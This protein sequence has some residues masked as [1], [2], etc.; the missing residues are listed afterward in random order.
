MMDRDELMHLALYAAKQDR[1][2]DAIGYLRRIL[3]EQPDD[4]QA[5]YMLGALHA[6]IGMYD[7][8]VAEMSRAVEVAPRALPTASFQLGLLHLTAGRVAEAEQAWASLDELGEGNPLYLFKRGMLSLAADRFED[9]IADLQQGIALN[10]AN[11][12]LNEDMRKVIARAQR[13]M[14]TA[15]PTPEAPAPE[16]HPGRHVFVS[17][18]E[19]GGEGEPG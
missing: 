3:D 7:R 17:R 8:A 10:S 11:E 18:Y 12:S 1:N 5:L 15:Q 4:V 19:S 14:A 2:E 16:P 9:C 13:A 6:Q